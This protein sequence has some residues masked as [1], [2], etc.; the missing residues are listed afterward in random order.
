MK[1]LPLVAL[2]FV[3]PVAFA[4]A[5]IGH[6]HTFHLPTGGEWVAADL[7]FDSVKLKSCSGADEILTLQESY[8]VGDPIPLPV[9]DW[10]VATFRGAWIDATFDLPGGD[11]HVDISVGD[12]PIDLDGGLTVP[13]SPLPTITFG[14]NTWWSSAVPYLVPG[15]TITIASG[16]PAYSSVRAALQ[17][18]DLH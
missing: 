7:Y 12:I 11:L 1:S 16:H 4:G 5:E 14:T 17:H 10:C 6:P 2:F 3:A 15:Q 13:E 18:A 9:G 8:G